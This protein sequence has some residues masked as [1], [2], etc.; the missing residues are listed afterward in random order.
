MNDSLVSQLPEGLLVIDSR[1]VADQL[2]IDHGD[3]MQ[4]A[5]KKYQPQAEQAFGSLRFQNGVRKRE[6]GATTQKFVWLT[7]DQA[8]FYTTLSRN[9]DKVVQTKIKIVTEFSKMRKLLLGNGY[10]QVTTSVYIRRLERIRDHEIAYD[11][12]SVFKESAEILLLVEKDF[13]IPVQKMDLC[14]GSIGD[15]WRKYRQDKEWVDNQ[16]YRYIHKFLIRK[17]K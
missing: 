16:E 8:L 9:T 1:V 6:I 13:N 12:W 2:D 5:I 10:Q 7:E 11:L 14:D 17:L 15:H 4:N 3:W